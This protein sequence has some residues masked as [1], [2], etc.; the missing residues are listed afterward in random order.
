M[1][2]FSYYYTVNDAEET[3]TS[4]SVIQVGSP[5][6]SLKQAIIDEEEEE[7][8]AKANNREKSNNDSSND[9]NDKEND[10]DNDSDDERNDSDDND[11]TILN[12]ENIP[13]IGLTVEHFFTPAQAKVLAADILGT[14]VGS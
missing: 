13:Q 12:K 10:E 7:T 2:Y 4:I 5:T 11:N 9:N 1:Y 6:P 14:C 8:K 3:N